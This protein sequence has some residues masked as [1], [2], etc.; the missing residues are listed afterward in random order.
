MHPRPRLD[1]SRHIPETYS[2]VQ[3]SENL[4]EILRFRVHASSSAQNEDVQTTKKL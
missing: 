2:G 1:K 4:R 3:K